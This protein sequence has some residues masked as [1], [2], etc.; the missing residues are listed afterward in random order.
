[1]LT[2]KPDAITTSG[3]EAA[4]HRRLTAAPDANPSS[5]CTCVQTRSTTPATAM[6]APANV[7]Q[8]AA[9]RP[10]TC[11]FVALASRTN[12]KANPASNTLPTTEQTV[13]T[14]STLTAITP[15]SLAEAH[16]P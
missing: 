14:T 2:S 12:R 6:S 7:S 4:Y 13:A 1:M 10:A 15:R 8:R 11:C 9:D 16:N 5:N 3:S